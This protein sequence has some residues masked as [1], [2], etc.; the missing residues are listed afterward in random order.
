MR[1]MRRT[2]RTPA[3]IRRTRASQQ[4]AARLDLG[5]EP[6]DESARRRLVV[7]GGLEDV[8]PL[9]RRELR[10]P[11]AHPADVLDR[12]VPIEIAV[13]AALVFEV[14]D[15]ALDRVDE[16][17]LLEV[18]HVVLGALVPERGRAAQRRPQVLHDVMAP[19][20]VARGS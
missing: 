6:S 5:L 18:F 12:D 8:P 9:L 19:H 14:D 13:P 11:L 3:I 17:L 7:A 20:A 4:P 1:A 16:T 15:A 2:G 10:Q